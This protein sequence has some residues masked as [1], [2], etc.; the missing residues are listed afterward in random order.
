MGRAPVLLQVNVDLDPAKEGFR[1]EDLAGAVAEL[2]AWAAL[3][4]GV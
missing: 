2:P 1:P 4:C 3:M